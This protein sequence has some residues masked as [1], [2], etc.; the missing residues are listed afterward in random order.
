MGFF[1]SYVMC[2]IGIVRLVWPPTVISEVS[3]AG[4]YRM[5]TLQLSARSGVSIA[6]RVPD[7][8]AQHA[9]CNMVSPKQN[10]LVDF[11][12]FPVFPHGRTWQGP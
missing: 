1:F 2:T 10:T 8:E 5:H 12:P 7:S 11:G 6:Q 4:S 3:K 9:G